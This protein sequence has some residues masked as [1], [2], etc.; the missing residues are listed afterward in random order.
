[1]AL[2]SSKSLKS[3]QNV[4]RSLLQGL[5]NSS[6]SISINEQCQIDFDELSRFVKTYLIN[7]VCEYFTDIQGGLC[8]AEVYRY[9][10]PNENDSGCFIVW[11]EYSA[12]HGH[13]NLLLV[14]LFENT[15]NMRCLVIVRC[16]ANT[17]NVIFSLNLNSFGFFPFAIG[18]ICVIEHGY[19][20]PQHGLV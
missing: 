16:L 7:L 2:L 15:Q 20:Y 6:G 13:M 5:K 14:C 12:L 4:Q 3:C 10:N 19:S 17:C 1:M 11:R 9:E 18:H 8:V